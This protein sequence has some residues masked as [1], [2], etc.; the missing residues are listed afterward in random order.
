MIH[1]QYK[2]TEKEFLD[3]NFY[4][5]WQKPEKRNLR[6]AYYL[7][8]PILYLV[9]IGLIFYDRN[10]EGFDNF[11]IILGIIGFIALMLLTK[12]RIRPRFDK[13]ALQMIKQSA[14]DTILSEMELMFAETGITGKTQI[15]EVKY[16]WNAFQK[17]VIVNDCY[18][19]FINIRQAIVI[20][21]RAFKTKTE[22]D[23]FEKMLAQY[24]PLQA[25]LP[26]VNK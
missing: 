12:F 11:A 18:Y 13:Q 7:T 6:L 9:V 24:L 22:K 4:T 21:F 5:C 23:S 16:S 3:Y 8:T 26:A 1:L 17:K 20:P 15:A 10:K 19:L 14:P 2:L 25:D